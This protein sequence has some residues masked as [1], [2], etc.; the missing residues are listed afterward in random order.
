MLRSLWLGSLPP[1]SPD[2]TNAVGDDPRAAKLG[3]RL[4]FDT[5]L[6]ANGQVSCAS[7]HQ[8]ARHFSDGRPLAQGIGTANRKTM[9]L[10][11][12][13][14][15]PWFFWDGRKDS[16]WSQALGPLES[17][18]EHGGNRMQYVH[19]V[20]GD[21]VYRAEYEALFGPL[22]DLSDRARFPPDAG[23]VE[24]PEAHA[25][26]EAMAAEDRDTVTRIAV[27]L[28]KAIAAYERLIL[29][30]PSRF[31]AYVQALL[32]ND[33]EAMERTLAA[34]EVAGLR[35]FIGDGQCTRCHNGPLFTNNEFHNT[36][37]PVRDGL[38][39]DHGRMVG[40]EQAR[41]DPFNCLGRY[42]DGDEEDCAELR[43]ARNGS[44]LDGAFKTPTLRNVAEAAP[45]MH[46]GQ[47]ATLEQV[48]QHYNQATPGPLG[49]NEL[50]PL[51][52]SPLELARLVAFLG[53]LSGP[54]AIAPEWFC[55]P[56]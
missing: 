32:E 11:G 38:P 7:C 40:V 34:N 9:T 36:G 13:A 45:Y 50:L 31:D 18:V 21:E 37:I 25:A 35:L 15:S 1:L 27:N 49:H 5:R 22:P 19:R 39:P 3:Q 10:V 52:F 33:I 23:P 46:A 4:F 29:P 51:A 17:A 43:F 12:A 48:L 56:Q 41:A 16:Q 28:G 26:W 54:L 20:A 44:A 8:P 2:P 55:P 42:S 24:E 47:F 14:Y 30:G 6:S 53:T